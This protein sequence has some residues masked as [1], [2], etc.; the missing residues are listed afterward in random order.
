MSEVLARFLVP[1]LLLR[2][3]ANRIAR[4]AHGML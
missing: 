1:Y 3:L 2:G 4:A